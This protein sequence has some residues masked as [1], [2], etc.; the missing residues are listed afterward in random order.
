MGTVPPPSWWAV[1][2]VVL[3]ALAA[4][5]I[6][7]R[8]FRDRTLDAG[9]RTLIALAV[10]SLAVQLAALYWMYFRF[11]HGGLGKS[12][13]PVLVPCLVLLWAGLE[14]WVPPSRRV[15]AAAAL[16]LLLALLDAAVWGLVAIPAYYASL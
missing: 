7:R 15:H 2:V 16:V 3:T 9:T 11:D 8:L 6:G 10:V 12:L 14:A 13:F 1:V 4:L 5:G